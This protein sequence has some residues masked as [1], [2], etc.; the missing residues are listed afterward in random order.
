M[1]ATTIHNPSVERTD[2]GSSRLACE[3]GLR[4]YAPSHEDALRQALE[5]MGL[6]APAPEPEPV[7]PSVKPAREVPA[8]FLALTGSPLEKIRSLPSWEEL[9]KLR[10]TLAREAL[11]DHTGK[12][13]GDALGIHRVK[14]YPLIRSHFGDDWK[15]Q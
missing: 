14:V 12:E 3:C 9:Q 5:H 2:G 11:K 7:A 10:A 6:A 13:V 1:T 4:A 8:A 15:D